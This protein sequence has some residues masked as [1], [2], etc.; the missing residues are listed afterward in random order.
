MWLATA[1]LLADLLGVSHHLGYR[2][3]GIHRPDPWAPGIGMID[4]TGQETGRDG[5]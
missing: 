1:W 2:P 3:L 4:S 5:A